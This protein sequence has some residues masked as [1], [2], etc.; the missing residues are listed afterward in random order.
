VLQ[1][2]LIVRVGSNDVDYSFAPHLCVHS[3]DK[4]QYA[5]YDCTVKFAL[6]ASARHHFTSR[7]KYGLTTYS[8][9]SATT[10]EKQMACFVLFKQSD[11]ASCD[12]SNVALLLLTSPVN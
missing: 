9:Q 10:I 8:L 2:E 6:F 11:T 12:K 1:Q 5:K 7:R 3:P 4:Y